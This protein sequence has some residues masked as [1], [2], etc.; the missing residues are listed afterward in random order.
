M[1]DIFGPLATNE[2]GGVV[3]TASLSNP[4]GSYS[5][6]LVLYDGTS[7]E[8]LVAFGTT[9]APGQPVLGNL[10][11]G[12]DVLLNQHNQVAF[13]V[14]FDTYPDRATAAPFFYDGE[15]LYQVIK[16]GENSPGG[17][18]YS[19][20]NAVGLNNAGQLAVHGNLTDTQF[21]LYPRGRLAIAIYTYRTG[22]LHEIARTGDPL[23]NS[24]EKH[25][26]TRIT[27]ID[28]RGRYVMIPE[29]STR[30]R[31]AYV[32][33]GS[34]HTLVLQSGDTLPDSDG[35]LETFLGDFYNDAGQFVYRAALADPLGE[36]ELH[37][38]F[39]MY[40]D[41]THY[42]L[43]GQGQP[44]PGTDR[45]IGLFSPA[46]AQLNNAGQFAF[47]APLIDG[48]DH[49]DAILIAD[50]D[51]LNVVAQEGDPKPGQSG[52]Y[53]ALSLRSLNDSGQA[54]FS[55]LVGDRD[56]THF[57][58][59]YTGVLEVVLEGR[60]FLG[61]RITTAITQDGSLG[62]DG[63]VRFAYELADGRSGM[64]AWSPPPVP[65]PCST[66]ASMIALLACMAKRGKRRAL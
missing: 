20:S 29:L 57:Y 64:A 18:R 63:L 51:S 39:Y 30:E 58:D 55:S 46:R 54:L 4:D 6:S 2:A 50:G 27:G 21:P 22:A 49:S 41:G 38:A 40:S 62:E 65:E 66:S 3:F 12:T 8:K 32:V 37:H 19:A 45:T 44:V 56:T 7:H 23:L 15:S 47:E 59:P 5:E 14:A 61:S 24:A 35:I 42:K 36:R 9:Y 34:S 13:T 60:P 11:Y 31:R 1:T 53:G 33:D 48:S 16:V 43:A 52:R 25:W 28:E 10:D 17:G 26:S